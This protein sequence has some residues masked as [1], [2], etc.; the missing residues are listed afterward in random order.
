MGHEGS[1]LSH[2]VLDLCD[3]V[4]TIEMTEGVMSFNVGV[5]AS[6]IMYTLKD[7]RTA[8]YI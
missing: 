1:G 7:K 8:T 5:A 6:L 3:E 4:I 2:E